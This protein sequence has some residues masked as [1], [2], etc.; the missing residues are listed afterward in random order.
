VIQAAREVTGKEIKTLMQDRRPGDP[1]RL[2]ADNK[3]A[4]AVLGWEPQQS[5][6]RSII[7]SA[8]RWHQRNP[9]GYGIPKG[10]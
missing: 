5:D 1:P 4:K 7:E 2:V 9:A 10:T 3:K 6:L 8:W